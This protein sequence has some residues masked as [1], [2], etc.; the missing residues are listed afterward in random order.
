MLHYLHYLGLD[1]TL[2]HSANSDKVQIQSLRLK[3]FAVARPRRPIFASNTLCVL[4]L[5][6]ILEAQG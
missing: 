6:C 4:C 5:L 1:T 3:C 2:E